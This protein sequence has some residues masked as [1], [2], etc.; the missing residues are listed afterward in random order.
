MRRHL[1]PSLL[2]LAASV[3]LAGAAGAQSLNMGNAVAAPNAGDVPIATIRTDIDLVQPATASGTIG[4][5]R[6]Q[7][8][9]AR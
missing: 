3:W 1:I 4:S 6:P 8:I 9:S 5:L 2:A 7:G